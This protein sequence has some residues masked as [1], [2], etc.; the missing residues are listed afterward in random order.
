MQTLLEVII[1]ILANLA[2]I[3]GVV[4]AFLMVQF[5]LVVGGLIKER[6]RNS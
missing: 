4:V 3:G 5:L 2:L 6:W 1:F